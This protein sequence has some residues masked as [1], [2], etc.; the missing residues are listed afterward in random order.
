MSAIESLFGTELL[1]G[2]SNFLRRSI[3]FGR[4]SLDEMDVGGSMQSNLTHGAED[5]NLEKPVA[6]AS[7]LKFDGRIMDSG[8]HTTASYGQLI[9]QVFCGVVHETGKVSFSDVLM[10]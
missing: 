1:H 3:G 6:Y 10:L 7:I 4:F 9:G 8:M 2:T 5:R